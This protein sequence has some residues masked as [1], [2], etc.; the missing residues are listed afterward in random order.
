MK[1]LL[2]PQ[3]RISIW[4]SAL[5]GKWAVASISGRGTMLDLDNDGQGKWTRNEDMLVRRRSIRE[6]KSQI[7]GH[8]QVYEYDYGEILILIFRDNIIVDSQHHQVDRRP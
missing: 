7:D 2:A 1:I 5:S 4:P 6:Q 8:G 3:L